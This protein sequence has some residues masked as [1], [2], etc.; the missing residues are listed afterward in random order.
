M[1]FQVVSIVTTFL[2]C[3]NGMLLRM[4]WKKTHLNVELLKRADVSGLLK[5][6]QSAQQAS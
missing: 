6:M 5:S 1:S 3:F 4:K 2:L